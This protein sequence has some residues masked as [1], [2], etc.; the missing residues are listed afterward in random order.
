MIIIFYFCTSRQLMGLHGE[1][2]T[3]SCTS[4]KQH[5]TIFNIVQYFLSGKNT[6][7]DLQQMKCDTSTVTTGTDLSVDLGRIASDKG[8]L[9]SN[10]PASGNCMFYALSEQLNSVKGIRISQRELRKTLV[11]FLRENPNLVSS[12]FSSPPINVSLFIK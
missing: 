10:N 11:R 1:R 3:K 6:L 5:A 8:F 2:F 7:H 4:L 9:I 12:V